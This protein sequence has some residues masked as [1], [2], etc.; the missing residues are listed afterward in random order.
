M[1]FW[2]DPHMPEAKRVYRWLVR[3]GTLEPYIAKKVTK[4]SFSV[5][6]T[7]HNYLNHTYYYPG[8]VEWQT[9]DIVF[10]DPAGPDVAS[11]VLAI[12][13]GSGYVP[14]QASTHQPR[15]LGKFMSGQ[16]L[17]KVSIEQ[18]DSF[19]DA[20]ETW[21]LHNPFIKDVKF[22]ELSYESDDMSDVTL[23]LRYDYATLKTAEPSFPVQQFETK[24]PTTAT[25]R[26]F[27]SG[28]FGATTP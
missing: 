22:A 2:N 7:K 21:S 14:P 3:M 16:S 4:P 25:P 18:L 6:E 11:T 12:M 15:T 23:T 13:E 24:S 27:P 19:G 10:V 28:K 9:I 8:R 26:E 17:G 5:T 20:I 1:G